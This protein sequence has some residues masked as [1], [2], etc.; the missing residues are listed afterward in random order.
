MDD[1][2]TPMRPQINVFV[3]LGIVCVGFIGVGPMI[4]VMLALPFYDGS[5]MDL[6]DALANPL[7]HPEVKLPFFIIQGA[8]TLFGL[9]VVPALVLVA[10]KQS[11]RYFSRVPKT[12]LLLYGLVAFSTI[13]FMVVNSP[14]I[15][16]N[17]TVE[18]SGFLKD[19]GDWARERE[20]FA[21]DVTQFLTVFGSTGEFVLGMIVIALLPALGEEFIF[22]GLL[23][24]QLHKVTGNIHVG[25]WISAFLFSAM[26]LQFFGFVPRMLLGAFFGYLYYWSGN[27]W[28]AA[29]AHFVNNGFSVLMLYSY[30]QGVS[31]LDM[32]STEAAPLPVVAGAAVITFILLYLF[33]KQATA[34]RDS[35]SEVQ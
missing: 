23:Q 28:M 26:H 20:D 14:V 5:I 24:P 31:D 16:W 15:E 3:L 29:L 13:C 34:L 33:K 12:P 25:I 8:T 21:A 22:R 30:Q 2:L 27:F 17:S 11:L 18:F 19:F 35:P 6:L 10:Q 1:N 9:M 4:G 7:G 32:N